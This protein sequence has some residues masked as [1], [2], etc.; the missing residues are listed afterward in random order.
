M[1]SSGGWAGNSISLGMRYVFPSRGDSPPPC[2]VFPDR[3]IQLAMDDR[4]DTDI[5]DLRIF[6]RDRL[7]LASERLLQELYSTG[8]QSIWISGNR[9]RFGAFHTDDRGCQSYSI[10]GDVQR[11]SITRVC[12]CDLWLGEYSRL[13]C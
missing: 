13:A 1:E 9:N 4:S 3:D 5:Q 6:G 12:T 10:Y 11:L 2:I 7:V 8:A